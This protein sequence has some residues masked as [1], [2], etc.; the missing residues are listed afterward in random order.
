MRMHHRN[1][2]ICH[3]VIGVCHG[4]VYVIS[5]CHSVSYVVKICHRDNGICHIIPARGKVCICH[6]Y[7]S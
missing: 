7:V 1:L 4:D 6:Q 2:Y 5:I 3:G